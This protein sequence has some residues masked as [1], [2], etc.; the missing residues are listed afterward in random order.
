M[1]ILSNLSSVLLFLSLFYAGHFS[2]DQNVLFA[3]TVAKLNRTNRIVNYLL[4]LSERALYLVDRDTFRLT[5]RVA[6]KSIE[7]LH[8][9]DLADHFLVIMVSICAYHWFFH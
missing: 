2:G 9:S 5:R 3:D 1:L 6:L 8:L 7:S 4:V